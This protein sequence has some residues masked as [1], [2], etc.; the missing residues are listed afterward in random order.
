MLLSLLIS[1][2]LGLRIGLLGQLAKLSSVTP[3]AVEYVFGEY[4]IMAVHC[5]AAS[6]LVSKAGTSISCNRVLGR[7]H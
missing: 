4:G 7:L 1:L 6:A 5:R 2:I 3:F